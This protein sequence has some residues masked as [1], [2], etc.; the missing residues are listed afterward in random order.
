M[1]VSLCVVECRES[2][3]CCTGYCC[4]CMHACGMT[5]LRPPGQRQNRLYVHNALNAGA[6]YGWGVKGSLPV[7]TAVRVRKTHLFLLC[8]LE[9]I[10]TELA[11]YVVYIYVVH[12]T[13]T[14]TFGAST[15]TRSTITGCACMFTPRRKAPPHPCGCYCCTEPLSQAVFAESLPSN[16][17][18][19]QAMLYVA[20]Q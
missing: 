8:L 11:D 7:S 20:L 6:C 4:M 17:S 16:V 9:T 15:V 13:G 12:I 5:L 2:C 18:I 3:C 10:R 19:S 1:P 14:L